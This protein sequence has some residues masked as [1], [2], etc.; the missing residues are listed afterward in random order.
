MDPG[1]V[2]WDVDRYNLPHGEDLAAVVISVPGQE[3]PIDDG[4]A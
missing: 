1:E 3:Q 2:A 4:T